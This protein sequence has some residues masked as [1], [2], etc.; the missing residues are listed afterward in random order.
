MT[1][2]LYLN[3]HNN[4]MNTVLNDNDITICNDNYEE[5]CKDLIY[6]NNDLINIKKR[7]E[8]WEKIGCENINRVEKSI[9]LSL[10]HNSSRN[11]EHIE[12]LM[13][14]VKD[15]LHELDKNISM[16]SKDMQIEICRFQNK[17]EQQGTKHFE[18]LRQEN[19]KMYYEIEKEIIKCFS[20]IKDQITNDYG[21][22]KSVLKNE[23]QN[24][25]DR[26]DNQSDSICNLL[27]DKYMKSKDDDYKKNKNNYNDDQNIDIV[28]D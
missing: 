7:I 26:V 19:L 22:L 21:E 16:S 3:L 13:E 2:E 8:E 28:S 10:E 27:I 12:K 5:Q 17:L 25:S 14:S 6:L 15:S 18:L 9:L 4:D 23:M 20:N 1:E 11:R 24:I